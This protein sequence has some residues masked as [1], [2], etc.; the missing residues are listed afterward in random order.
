MP[1][2]TSFSTFLEE[3]LRTP[4]NDRQAL[5]DALLD[6]RRT[7]PWIEHDRATFALNRPGTSSAAVN[8]DTL[9]GDPPFAPMT[10]LRGTRFWH[11]TLEFQPDDLLDYMI[12]IDDPMTPLAQE[13]DIAGRIA[14]HWGTDALNPL[15]ME[16]QQ[17]NV[18]VLRMH[19]ARPFPNWTQFDVPR[20][21]LYEH[22]LASEELGFAE[23]ALWVYTPP[24]YESGDGVY[25][26]LILHDGQW[27]V[28]P[29]QVPAMADVLIKHQRLQPCLIAMIQTGS[30]AERERE[31]TASDQHTRFLVSELLPFVQTRYYVDYSH[32]GVGGVAVGA[33][34]AAHAALAHPALFSRLLMISPPL[35]RGANQDALRG[36]V[37]ALSSSDVLPSRIFQSVGR[38]EARGR[39]LRPGRGLRDTLSTRR[40]IAYHFEEIGSGHGLV[41]FR[42]ILPEALAWTLPG[43]AWG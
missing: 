1:R 36:V 27:M 16:T 25:P 15:R 19:E 4:E 34:A 43:A 3:A 5:V 21:R 7:W 24:G 35:G 18:S 41:G 33:V 31:Y 28:G 2:W 32:I 10:Q 11:V 20:G 13:T 37:N 30:A 40:D 39:F 23:R 22:T 14:R 8:L 9:P 6:E 38:Y 17:M 42:S 12:A 26:L 29:L